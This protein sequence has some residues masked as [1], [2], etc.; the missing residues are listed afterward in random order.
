M[1]MVV[2]HTCSVSTRRVVILGAVILAICIMAAFIVLA[3]Q[4]SLIGQLFQVRDI[5]H[6][7]VF[8]LTVIAF[9]L[10]VFGSAV[11]FAVYHR[12]RM[13]DLVQYPIAYPIPY[14]V[15]AVPQ[16]PYPQPSAYPAQQP[17]YPNIQQREGLN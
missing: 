11:G 12:Q 5:L 14:P 10:G 17:Q 7:E 9:G 15:H 2:G 8:A 4:Y 3:E 6:H 1:G 13:A 16:V